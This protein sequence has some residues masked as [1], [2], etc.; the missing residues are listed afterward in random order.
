MK[1]GWVAHIESIECAT[2]PVGTGRAPGERSG[3]IGDEIS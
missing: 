2:L 3:N 1:T